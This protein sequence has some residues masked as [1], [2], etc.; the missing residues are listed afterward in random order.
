MSQSSTFS[1]AP[2]GALAFLAT[3]GIGWNLFMPA[4]P[5]AEENRTEGPETKQASRP[6]RTARA[7]AAETAAMRM[8]SIRAARDPEAR[9]LATLALADSLSPSDFAAWVD[10][11]YF[12]LRGGPE[13]MMF[14]KI[15]MDRWRAEDPEG[16]LAWAEKNKNGAG[17]AVTEQ[18]AA[19]D[20]Q[21]LLAWFQSHRN[22]QAEISLL[23]QI[24]A[25]SPEL[26][27]QRLREMTEAG[28]AGNAMRSSHALMKVLA[29]KS[30]A[31][32]Q[33]MLA[34]LPADLKIHAESALG[35]KRLE[36]SFSEGIRN[37]WDRAD[38][39]RIFT[40]M[41][42]P[43]MNKKLMG[44]LANLPAEWRRLMASNSYQFVQGG[45]ARDWLKN[46]LTEAGFS[47]S[48]VK[49]IRGTALEQLS[50]IDPAATIGQL[51]VMEIEPDTRRQILEQV[52]SSNAGNLRELAEQLPED[53]KKRAIAMIDGGR[54][55]RLVSANAKTTPAELLEKIVA[56]DP[57]NVGKNSVFPQLDSWDRGKVEALTKGFTALP[58]DQKTRAAGFIT[59]NADLATAP[60]ELQGAALR[61]LAGQPDAAAGG[62]ETEENTLTAKVCTHAARLAT[63][64]PVAAASWVGSLPA[65]EARSWA[66]SNLLNGW[67]QYDPEAAAS[68][69]KSLSPAEREAIE[70][71]GM[72]R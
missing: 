9:M 22:D 8:G 27:L 14:T 67:V 41:E 11:G 16:L 57:G 18:W 31:A 30:P 37:L 48:E 15:L 50:Y 28:M 55:S 35:R 3:A 5:Q 70:K 12:D 21:R 17:A 26:A 40:N 39:W 2:F 1:I 69:K 64:D 63:A 7:V 51:G 58:A 53:E 29:D 62:K 13:L 36:A 23:G 34:S 32:L 44:E 10:G 56:L 66:Q 20:P 38:G 61:Y 46:D 68:W 19:K 71:I 25:H 33:A 54:E 6:G 65:G 45:N 42:S 52:F 47:D 60:S 72:E 4:A 24:A 43:E 59:A 49:R